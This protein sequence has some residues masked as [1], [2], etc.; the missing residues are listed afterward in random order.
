VI[1]TKAEQS[2]N[3][4]TAIAAARELA[5]LIEL[6]GRLS[7]EIDTAPQLNIMF[8]PTLIALQNTMMAALVEHPAAKQAVLLALTGIGKAPLLIEG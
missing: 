3:F 2:G 7:H 5:R 6:Q 8:S 1:M 4:T